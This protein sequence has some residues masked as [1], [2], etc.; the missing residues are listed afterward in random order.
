V[1]DE[2]AECVSQSRKVHVPVEELDT[3]AQPETAKADQDT[4]MV[5][6]QKITVDRF[7]PGT[8]PTTQPQ[9]GDRTPLPPS[10]SRLKKK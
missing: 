1:R 10:A 5:T 9:A 7:L 6:R 4:A 3:L 2:L 8:Q